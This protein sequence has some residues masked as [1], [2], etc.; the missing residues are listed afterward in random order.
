MKINSLATA[1]NLIV[2][3]LLLSSLFMLSGCKSKNPMT[4]EDTVIAAPNTPAPQPA[5]QNPQTQP[6]P[7]T[8]A[9]ALTPTKSTFGRGE[10]I[11]FTITARNTTDAAQSLTFASGKRFDV[12]ATPEGENK[13]AVWRWSTGKAFTMIFGNVNWRPGETK[14]WTATWDQTDNNNNP[15]PRGR[16]VIQAE[17]ASTPRLASPPTTIT[18]T[19]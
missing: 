8:I 6:A 5:N 12:V 2:S 18:L 9:V 1:S 14:T 7:N 4:T 17:L 16:F 15:L 10:T 3:G 19:D 13:E 11:T